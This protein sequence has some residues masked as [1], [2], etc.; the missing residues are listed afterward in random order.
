MQQAQWRAL[1]F[2]VTVQVARFG[3]IIG[4]LAVAPLLGVSGWYSGLFVN[5]LCCLYAAALITWGGLWRSTGFLTL[6]RG[7]TA[8]LLLLVPLG[9]ALSWVVPAGPVERAPGYALW[10]LSL[11]M[12]GFNEELISRG[13]VLSRLSRDY[14]AVPA[15]AITGLLFGLQHLS[16]LVTT[17]RGAIDIVTNVL[18]SAC[19]GF[20]LAAFQYRFAWVA[21]LIV[22][23]GL[24]DFTTLLASNSFG[25]VVVAAISVMYLAYGGLILTSIRRRELRRP[26]APGPPSRR[27]RPA[28]PTR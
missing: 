25:D 11:L 28:P 8:A 12:V 19:Y 9:E 1:A 27:R 6:W 5:T 17:S 26:A 14:G 2:A 18:A 16:L 20:G 15:V 13:V 3:V 24:S 7:R 10:A 21:P 4:G 22:L 23:H